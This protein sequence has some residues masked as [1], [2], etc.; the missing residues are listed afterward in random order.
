MSRCASRD[1]RSSWPPNA[2]PRFCAAAFAIEPTAAPPAPKMSPSRPGMFPVATC[3]APVPTFLRKPPSPIVSLLPEV[4]VL[5]FV[6]PERQ[7]PQE[8]IVGH[9]QPTALQIQPAPAQLRVDHAE[10]ALERQRLLRRQ[11]SRHERERLCDLIPSRGLLAPHEFRLESA[12]CLSDMLGGHS[13]LTLQRAAGIR[14]NPLRR[15]RDVVTAC[16][17]LLGPEGIRLPLDDRIVRVDV[18]ALLGAV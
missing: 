9:I 3:N 18:Q 11:P 5:V 14:A 1:A 13:A 4:V 7:L 6:C 10:L 12:G 2:A 17:L 15:V 16:A 8:L